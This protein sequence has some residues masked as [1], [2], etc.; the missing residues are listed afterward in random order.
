MSSQKVQ[1]DAIAP[2]RLA[3][4]VPPNY[5]VEEPPV[6]FTKPLTQFKCYIP[7]DQ[8]RPGGADIVGPNGRSAPQQN[9]TDT[10]DIPS[11]SNPFAHFSEA[12]LRLLA[13][14]PATAPGTLIWL[15]CHHNPDIRASVARN[16]KTPIETIWL[17]A[18][19]D[20]AGV[21]LSI[22]EN[23]QSSPSVL[24]VLSEDK[25]QL[26][27][28]RANNT[29]KLLQLGQRE[30]E[31]FKVDQTV[32]ELSSTEYD[33][34]EEP[35]QSSDESAP[36]ELQPGDIV[37]LD[38]PP[39][40]TPAPAPTPDT[41]DETLLAFLTLIAHKASTPQRRL[42]ELAR[43]ANPEIR[44]AVAANDNASLEI[45]WLLSRDRDK[46][47]REKLLENCNCPIEI[48]EAL[49]D[50]NDQFIAWSARAILTRLLGGQPITDDPPNRETP[51]LKQISNP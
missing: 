35:A 17:L 33:R 24:Q 6:E 22:A 39:P 21:R 15:A 14:S 29:L 34:Y 47:V 27:A 42:Y 13:E 8:N 3:P 40:E 28:W 1:P 38:P 30:M 48:L 9:R 18:Q 25:N 43:H 32:A 44:A 20:E 7:V 2:A 50:D 11:R 45:M 5:T 16:S 41:T 46:E 51:R 4:S 49:Q 10:T 26:V 37:D 31:Q 36:Y 19:D 23:S 12:S